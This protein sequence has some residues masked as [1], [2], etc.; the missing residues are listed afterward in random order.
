M[1]KAPRP[2]SL[3]DVPDPDGISRRVGILASLGTLA[4]P[5]HQK[6][7]GLPTQ[8]ARLWAFLPEH[9]RLG[10]VQIEAGMAPRIVGFQSRSVAMRL[11]AG[12]L[13]SGGRM[14]GA[15]RCSVV[16]AESGGVVAGVPTMTA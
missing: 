1:R 9:E 2:V 7:R 11:S 8:I 12:D 13:V 15:V 6:S 3:E 10:T 14:I 5:G 4:P 16:R